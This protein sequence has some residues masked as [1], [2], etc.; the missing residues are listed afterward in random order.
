MRNK[1]QPA[2]HEEDRVPVKFLMKLTPTLD[3]KLR[4]EAKSQNRSRIAHLEYI[5][6]ERY[7]KQRAQAAPR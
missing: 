5:L 4:A 3:E 2:A 6:Q 7:G 1:K